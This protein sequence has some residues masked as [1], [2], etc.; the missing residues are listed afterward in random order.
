MTPEPSWRPTVGPMTFMPPPGR[1]KPPPVPLCLDPTLIEY[2]TNSPFQ[3]GV[4]TGLA[5]P[6]QKLSSVS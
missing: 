2:T 4:G 6:G 3:S 1:V 5:L